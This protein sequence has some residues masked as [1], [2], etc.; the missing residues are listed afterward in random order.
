MSITNQIEDWMEIAKSEFASLLHN[1]GPWNEYVL[2]HMVHFPPAV[3]KLIFFAL[4]AIPFYGLLKSIQ[5][6]QERK[7]D[8]KSNDIFQSR[9]AK[10]YWLT[11]ATF[12]FSVTTILFANALPTLPEIGSFDGSNIRDLFDAFYVLTLTTQ[13]LAVF[14][15][16]WEFLTKWKLR[17]LIVVCFTADLI[18]MVHSVDNFSSACSIITEVQ[19]KKIVAIKDTLSSSENKAS[20]DKFHQAYLNRNNS[21][22]N[23]NQSNKVQI[24]YVKDEF[25]KTLMK[26]QNKELYFSA[27]RVFDGSVSEFLQ[28]SEEKRQEIILE[29][30]ALKFLK[31]ESSIEEQSGFWYYAKK[32]GAFLQEYGGSILYYAGK[33]YVIFEPFIHGLGFTKIADLVSFIKN[34]CS[35]LQK[36]AGIIGYAKD[37][38][39]KYLDFNW[40]QLP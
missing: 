1:S 39:Q 5:A 23:M 37:F 15:P 12:T 2:P 10:I 7:H 21:N 31:Q 35:L 8:G 38:C 14:Y 19:D 32:I 22:E 9:K 17:Y 11:I 27:F 30:E 4:R 29:N 18:F 13:I 3:A 16:F 20:F 26:I 24:M 28:T 36:Q 25:I 40:L 6:L 34:M 33:A